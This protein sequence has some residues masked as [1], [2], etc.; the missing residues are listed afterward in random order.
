MKQILFRADDLGYSEGVNY[1]IAKTVRGGI[2]KNVGL[3]PNMKAA[4]HGVALVNVEQICLG[5]HTNICIG[6]PVSN[7]EKIPSLVNEDGMF[8]RSSVYRSAES[9]FVVLEE[10][11]IEIEA[12]YRRFLELTGRQPGYFEGHA[13]KSGNFFKGLQIVAERHGLKYV[14]FPNELGEPVSIGDSKVYMYAGSMAER[15]PEECLR[16]VVENEPEDRTGMI[17]YH[18]GYLDAYILENSSLTTGRV[19]EAKML[20]SKR[21]RKYLQE[22]NVRSITCDEL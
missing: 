8:K 12:Q 1:G 2:I 9:D 5:Q 18:P 11:V 20:C 7:P 17:I 15:S 14:P 13:V 3:M 10:V 22:E 19:Y 21:V 16:Q 6:R 4:A